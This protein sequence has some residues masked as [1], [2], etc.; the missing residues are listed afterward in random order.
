MMSRALLAVVFCSWIFVAQADEFSAKVIAV[1]D[2]DT[3]LIKRANGVTKV[4][5]AGIDAPEK[6]QTFGATSKQSLAEMVSGKQIHLVTQA[7]DKYGRL[8]ARISVNGLDVNAEQIRRGMA[9]ESSRFHN[10]K[11]M[12]KLQ[13]EAKNAPRGLWAL[14]N[15]VPPWKWRKQHPFIAKPRAD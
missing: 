3:V 14:S 1:F 13:Q 8:I 10:D 11:A 6:T 5:L 2:G 7:V 12:L 15:P 9:W 4:R